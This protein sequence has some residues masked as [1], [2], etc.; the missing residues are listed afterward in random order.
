MTKPD[1]SS[2]SASGIVK[3]LLRPA[4]WLFVLPAVG[5]GFITYGKSSLDTEM[6]AN[7][8]QS[9][10]EDAELDDARKPEVKAVYRALPPSKVC[11]ADDTELTGYRDAVCKP[12][13]TMWQFIWAERVA[14]VALV[15]GALGLAWALA[16]GR[17]ASVW[18]QA[19]YATFIAG[20]RGLTL[21]T[22]SEAVLQGALGVWL[23]Y[24]VTAL[25]THRYFPKL[26][27][28]AGAAAGLAVLTVV[29]AIF[30]RPPP[31]DPLEAEMV[32][33]S[34]AP[35]VWRRL[36]DLAARTNTAPPTNLVAG[37]DDNFFVT[38]S[39]LAL[40]NSALSGRTLYVS[41]PLL[42]VLEA[43][44]ADAI[45]AHELAHFRGGDTVF[46]AKLG[47]A[48]SQ[49]GVYLQALY[50]GGVTIPAFHVMYL[51][52]A[53]FELARSK[54][55]RRR[56]LVADATAASLLSPNDLGKALLKVAAY[57][58]FRAATEQQL[59]ANQEKLDETLGIQQ[60]VVEGLPTHVSSPHFSNDLQTMN[61]P[62]PFDSHPPLLERLQA[63]KATVTATDA[64]AL[65]QTK[66][67]SSWAD[68]VMT[69][70][71]IEARLWQA[72][73]SRFARAHEQSLAYRYLPATDAERVL[74]EKFFPP[75]SFALK[76]GGYVR[77]THVGFDWAE[78][79]AGPL[80]FR[81]LNECKVEDGTFSKQFVVTHA[82]AGQPKPKTSKF[83]L[84]H[85]ADAEAFK[86]AFGR[87][88]TRDQAARQHAATQAS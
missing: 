40:P 44:E 74:V 18:P 34:D 8:E 79:E 17:I 15:L 41:L 55:Q 10:D 38:E 53:V 42:R 7:I 43:S 26:I 49:Y 50:E 86:E 30:K 64:P 28:I 39:Q 35:S 61:V 36:T 14:W 5:L 31:P 85:L 72:Y 77:I 25:L 46:S 70:S 3:A 82:V 80:T 9:I 11:A 75:V 59:F 51:F 6:L 81:D 65:L 87:Y 45:L 33:Q 67:A 1:E 24:W 12:G 13:A 47:P 84:G 21:V 71:A 32:L 52:R 4:L 88:W 19:Q 68:D 2:P 54:E 69:G 66:P 63:V 22:A 23:S 56:E 20:W 27:L 48:L 62:H 76:K 73:E 37:I 83:N 60:R 78:S 58:S 16:L 29:R 57:S